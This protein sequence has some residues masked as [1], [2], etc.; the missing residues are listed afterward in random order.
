MSI[1]KDLRIVVIIFN[2]NLFIHLFMYNQIV[3]KIKLTKVKSKTHQNLEKGH[4]KARINC[5]S[6]AK[7]KKIPKNILNCEKVLSLDC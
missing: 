6:G 2:Q 1:L 4:I 3:T 7:Y 5:H